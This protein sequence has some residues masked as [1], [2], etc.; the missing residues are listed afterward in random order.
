MYK[1]VSVRMARVSSAAAILVFALAHPGLCG[2]PAISV[3]MNRILTPLVSEHD[4]D[5]G[6]ME[7]DQARGVCAVEIEVDPGTNPGGWVLYIRSDRVRFSPDGAGKPCSDLMWKLDEED[8]KSYRRLSDHEAVV[9]ENPEGGRA[10]IMLDILI[11]L[12]WRTDPGTYGIELQL[13]TA[14]L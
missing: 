6:F 3:V 7:L 13:R 9:L 1:P 2:Q 8:G 11:A 12:D 4:L 14:F 10:L 5:A